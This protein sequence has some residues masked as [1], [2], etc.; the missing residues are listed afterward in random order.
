MDTT[1][2]GYPI[3]QRVSAL[4]LLGTNIVPLDSDHLT[5]PAI[6]RLV[7]QTTWSAPRIGLV[8]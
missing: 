6:P 1:A 5:P 3:A 8:R 2:T 7:L 4:A